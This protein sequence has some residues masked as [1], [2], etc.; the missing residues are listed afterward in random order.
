MNISIDKQNDLSVVVPEGRL[1]AVGAP[2]LETCGKK[3]VQEG[4]RRVLLDMG[5]VVYISSAGL[6]TLLVLVKT[7]KAAGGKMVLC[8]LAPAVHEVMELS[9]FLSIL[10]VAPDRAGAGNLLA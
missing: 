5:K 4:A 2:E 1:D 6:R 7:M 3:L 8:G 10:T 9:G